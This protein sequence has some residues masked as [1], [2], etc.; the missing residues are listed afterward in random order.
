MAGKIT[1]CKTAC[2][3][4]KHTKNDW[5]QSDPQVEWTEEEKKFELQ[6]SGFQLTR[7]LSVTHFHLHRGAMASTLLT[8]VVGIIEIKPKFRD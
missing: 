4:L 1:I 3:H 7:I 6:H 8:P 5:T 2:L